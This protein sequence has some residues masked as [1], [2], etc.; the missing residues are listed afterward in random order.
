MVWHLWLRNVEIRQHE[1]LPGHSPAEPAACELVRRDQFAKVQRV[2]ACLF[3]AHLQGIV[4]IL[5]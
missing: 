4:G 2:S 1:P 5:A 3:D